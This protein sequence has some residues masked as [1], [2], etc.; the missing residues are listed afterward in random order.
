MNEDTPPSP[1]TATPSGETTTG[2][3]PPARPGSVHRRRVA[4]SGMTCAACVGR[5]ERGLAKVDGIESVSVNLATGAATLDL[6]RPFPDGEIAGHLRKLGYDIKTDSVNTSTADVRLTI[7]DWIPFAATLAVF[8]LAMI[9][10]APLMGHGGDLLHRLAMPATGW[11]HR[12][13]SFLWRLDP[14]TLRVLLLALHL[15]VV[16]WWGRALLG[17][18]AKALV[19]RSPDMNSLVVTGAS[20]AFWI[21]ALAT[22][23]PGWM[24]AHGLAVEVYFESVSGVL[25]FVLLGKWL[26]ERSKRKAREAIGSLATLLPRRAWIV[27][28]S[29]CAEIDAA[30]LVPGDRVRILPH[31]RVPADGTLVQGQ[32]TFDESHLTGESLPR[33]AG[34]GDPVHAGAVNGPSAAE[35]LVERAGADTQ[36]AQV[37]KL[38]EE[39]QGSKAPA[40][41]MADR[42]SR[43]FVPAVMGFALLAGLLW[44]A[45]GPDPSGPRAFLVAI[46]VLVVACPCALGLAVPSAIL[47]AI[48]RAARNGIL[49]RDAAALEALAG[50]DTVVFDKTGT[51]TE[52]SPQLVRWTV[53]EDFTLEQVLTLAAALEE[54]SSHPMARPVVEAARA[55]DCAWIP[56][57]DTTTLPGKGVEART[58]KSRTRV[59]S[60]DWIGCADAARAGETSVVVEVNGTILGALYL[61]DPLRPESHRAVR[62]LERL[63]IHV[64][65]LSGDGIPAVSQAAADLGLRSWRARA[66]PESKAERIRELQREG[67]RVLM[68]GDGVNDAVA[69]AQADASLAVASGSATAFEG[70]MGSIPG[71]DP[72][73]A[74]AAIELGRKTKSVIQQNLAWAFGYNLLL[75]P[76]AAGALWPFGKV[77]LSPALAGAAMSVSSVT[78]ML[79]SLRLLGWR[80]RRSS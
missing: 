32:A 52:G 13:A 18:G 37:T 66:T 69:L 54:H 50:C 77:L 76:V 43:V 49:L 63:G 26:E 70:A 61:T 39:A 24:R 19:A 8:V 33:V 62:R 10:G 72:S 5:I 51:L 40:Q 42:I 20:A 48:G 65:I 6:S 2:T 4:V 41:R 44:W 60:P 57:P 80:A 21:S 7:P 9:L 25:G 64:E 68:V 78:V 46:S 16:L 23:A 1:A 15:P 58:G 14:S 56:V 31:E 45:L 12:H 75:L 73:L 30:L 27:R 3:T 17:R 74:A 35:F 47:V 11:L 71:T 36:V 34:P 53:A 59:G 67:H 28:G 38:V 22:L 29:Y 79:N 55:R